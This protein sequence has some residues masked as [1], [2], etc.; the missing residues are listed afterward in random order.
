[1]FNPTTEMTDNSVV[2][3]IK[4]YVDGIVDD[5]KD[6]GSELLEDIKDAIDF[7][8]DGTVGDTV[9]SYAF[10]G[11][12]DGEARNYSAEMVDP[13]DEPDCAPWW[14]ESIP[15]EDHCEDIPLGS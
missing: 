8:K 6:F 1:M 10:A 12:S 14:D 15:W 13:W 9:G 7:D 5:I 3:D 4:D 2:D 11:I